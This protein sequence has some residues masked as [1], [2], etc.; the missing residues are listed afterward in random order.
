V[1]STSYEAP[2]YAVFS[3]SLDTRRRKKK[4]G[5]NKERWKEKRKKGKEGITA[6]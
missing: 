6:G 3:N 1:R 4:K 5:K 2:H